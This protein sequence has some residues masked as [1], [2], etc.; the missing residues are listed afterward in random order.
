[1]QSQNKNPLAISNSLTELANYHFQTGNFAESEQLHKQALIIREQNN[2]IGGAITNYIKLAEVLIKDSKH[3]EALEV[4]EK[5]LQ[6]A[7]QIKVKPKIYQVHL[8]LSEYLQ[9]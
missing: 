3:D 2:F 7:E 5:G 4:L 9:K 8:L 6:L 1:M